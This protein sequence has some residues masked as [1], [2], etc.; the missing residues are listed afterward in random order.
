MITLSPRPCSTPAVAVFARTN[1]PKG[2]AVLADR[3]VEKLKA[4]GFD[5]T[6]ATH[7]ER[8]AG[9]ERSAARPSERGTAGGPKALAEG[10]P[11]ASAP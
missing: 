10:P 9:D 2:G 1:L 6:G 11:R 7:D 3:A 8:V 4:L 5:T